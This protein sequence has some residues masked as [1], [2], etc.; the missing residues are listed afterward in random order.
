MYIFNK[1]TSDFNPKSAKN[2]SSHIRIGMPQVIGGAFVSSKMPI[3]R[4]SCRNTTINVRKITSMQKS[5]HA[6]PSSS[7][8]ICWRISLNSNSRPIDRP[9]ASEPPLFMLRCD[10][11]KGCYSSLCGNAIESKLNSS[12]FIMLG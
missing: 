10:C 11:M 12:S 4:D 9:D 2:T 8:E 3:L 5:H 7:D 1:F 6:W